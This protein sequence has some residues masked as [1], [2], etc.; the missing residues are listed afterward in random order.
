MQ[1]DFRVTEDWLCEYGAGAWELELF[2]KYVPD[3]S[4]SVQAFLKWCENFYFGL[5]FGMWLV[6]LPQNTEP[7]VIEE[8]TGGSICYNGDVHFKKGFT[9]D[10][11]LLCRRLTVDGVL[12]WNKGLVHVLELKAQ[13][14][15]VDRTFD[16]LG[17]GVLNPVKPRVRVDEINVNGQFQVHSVDARVIKLQSSGLLF[18]GNKLKAEE[19]HLSEKSR[20]DA[21]DIE[22]SLVEVRGCATLDVGEMRTGKFKVISGGLGLNPPFE[23]S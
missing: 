12:T 19:I 15:N 1:K 16:H 3:G 23:D 14:L 18:V 10:G 4:C 22:A 11:V 13:I 5:H 7:L 6:H 21:K 2:R 17:N 8:Y 9:C 20:I